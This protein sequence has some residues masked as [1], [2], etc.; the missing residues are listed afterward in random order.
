MAGTAVFARRQNAYFEGLKNAGSL[1]V[2]PFPTI[3]GQEKQYTLFSEV[4]AYGIPKGAKNAAA[5]P[6][7]LRFFLDRSNYD[8]TSFFCSNQ[9]LE[10]YEACMSQENRLW[11]TLYDEQVNFYGSKEID[12]FTK[13]LEEATGTQVPSVLDSTSAIIDQR[14]KR[15]NEQLSNMRE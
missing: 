5:V 12:A 9:A 15:Y 4:E 11:T 7:F 3:E 1:M 13:E 10:V 2:V 8:E 14:I 6:Y